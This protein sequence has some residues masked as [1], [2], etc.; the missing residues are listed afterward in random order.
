MR[1]TLLLAGVATIFTLSN[2]VAMEINPY[3]SAK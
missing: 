1:K 3:V 2:A